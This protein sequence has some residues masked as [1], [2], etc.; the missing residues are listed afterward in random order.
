M[1]LEI[2]KETKC[3]ICQNDLA[4]YAV[5]VLGEDGVTDRHV[6]CSAEEGSCLLAKKSWSLEQWNELCDMV[7]C[8]REGYPGAAH[9]R[10]TCN[11]NLRDLHEK[12]KANACL[13]NSIRT[14]DPAACVFFICARELCEATGESWL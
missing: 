1:R 3:P 7:A 14:D 8:A 4:Y 10:L 11:N 12:W 5:N 9:D 6:W 13:M 2:L